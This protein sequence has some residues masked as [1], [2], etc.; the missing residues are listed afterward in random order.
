PSIMRVNPARSAWTMAARRRC[1]FPYFTTLLAS[2][3][4]EC[5]RPPFPKRAQALAQVLR[6][7]ALTDALP[8]PRNVRLGLGELLDGPLH[9]RHGN[10][11]Q[12]RKFGRSFVDPGRELI[13]VDQPVQVADT[14]EVLVS[15]FLRQKE[16]P[17]GEARAHLLGIAAQPAR[18]VVQSKTRRRHEE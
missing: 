9:V 18:V 2:A 12:S 8:D 16:G 1:M 6:G 17:L 15:E 11:G 10:R 13:A 7:L 5:R 4:L 3:A 14:Q